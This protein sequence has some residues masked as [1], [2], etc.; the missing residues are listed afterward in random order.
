[1]KPPRIS[2]KTIEAIAAIVCGDRVDID[3][4]LSPYRSH[5][6][7]TE[8]FEEDLAILKLSPVE[9]ASRPKWT[10]SWL[11]H[12]NGTPELKKIVEASV[13]PS[14]YESTDFRVESAVEHLNRFLKHD[15]LRLVRSG[16]R[17]VL[18]SQHG[19]ALPEII[20]EADVLSV[21]YIQE[22]AGKCDTRL[23]DG[24]LEGAI[25]VARTMIEAV[26]TELEGRLCDKAGDYK[27][28]LG[29]QFKAV[30]KH[31]GMDAGRTDLD[32]NFKQVVN[33]LTNVVNGLAPIR[34]KMSDGH[35]RA[36]KPAPHH[37]RVIVNAAKT[38]AT[39]LIDSYIFQREKGLLNR[40]AEASGEPS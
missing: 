36:H 9:P 15:D 27:G 38:V 24:E 25:T 30:A 13:R 32:D 20:A 33:G 21:E 35:A 19:V 17:Y 1:M 10:A 4:S 31:L 40:G 8:F 23:S 39:F 16:K 34:N 3:K 11:K 6:K 18:T 5:A 37:A 2:F 29:K 12:T 7:L 22:L 26:L 14:D 28:E